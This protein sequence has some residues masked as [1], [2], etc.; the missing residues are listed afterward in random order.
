MNRKFSLGL[1][2]TTVCALAL[3]NSEADARDMSG[4]KFSG[5][6]GSTISAGSGYN[7]YNTD[8]R[9]YLD[10]KDR[11]GANLGWSSSPQKNVEL[12]K[13]T[14]SGPITCGELFAIKVDKE[15]VMYDKQTVGINLSTRTTYSDEWAQWKFSSCT[16]GQPVPLNQS[17]TLV[18]TRAVDSLVGCKRA[19]GVNLC[20]AGDVLSA[21][22]KNIRKGP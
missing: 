6:S 15:F 11:A 8:Q 20:W 9:L 14:G 3:S 13:K 22:G 18:N 19:A 1:G 2:I 7:M 4:W 21:G 12:K 17:V 10:D 5:G 16:A